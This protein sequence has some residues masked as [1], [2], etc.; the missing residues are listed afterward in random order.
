[1]SELSDYLADLP[2]P[3][4]TAIA[5]VYERARE[6]VALGSL[7]PSVGRWRVI[8]VEDA[9][10]LTEQACNALLKAIEEPPSRTVWVLCAP[11][12]QDVVVT[13]RSRCRELR[14]HPLPPDQMARVL[15][16]LG[17]EHDAAQLAA[18]SAGS[19]GEALRLSGQDG[20]ALYHRI[21]AL[22]AEY[23]R[24][25]RRAAAAVP[26]GR[27]YLWVAAD[28]VVTGTGA[29]SAAF[30]ASGASR[31]SGSTARSARA[32]TPTGAA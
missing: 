28:G 3:Q 27:E 21:V 1:M 26:L 30:R 15:H 25:E 16:N 12:P 8:I 22:F 9:D 31:T 18:L 17:V 23:P 29:V 19:V 20:L 2:E 24:M 32:R 7:R 10:R 11:S 6:L 14:L 13:I 4:R 5:A